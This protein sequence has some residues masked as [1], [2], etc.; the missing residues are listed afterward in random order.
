MF[1]QGYM[2]YMGGMGYFPWMGLMF[3][4][5]FAIVI[6]LFVSYLKKDNY[7]ETKSNNALEILEE[8]FAKGEISKEEFLDMKK[9]IR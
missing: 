8:R 4:I 9:T 6:F 1:G 2:G 5:V 3:F 7:R